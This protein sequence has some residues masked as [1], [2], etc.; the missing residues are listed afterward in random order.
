M[1]DDFDQARPITAN[2]QL[3]MDVTTTSI[4]TLL[5]AENLNGLE[6]YSTSSEHP[7]LPSTT[8]RRGENTRPEYG[9]TDE[10]QYAMTELSRVMRSTKN[11]RVLATGR[12]EMDIEE[13]MAAWCELQLGIKACLENAQSIHGDSFSQ[14]WPIK[15]DQIGYM[16]QILLAHFSVN[17]YLKSDTYGIQKFPA[18]PFL[19][20]KHNVGAWVDAEEA[21]EYC[22]GGKWGKIDFE[23]L[24]AAA[25]KWAN[26]Q[27][28]WK[29]LHVN[30]L[31]DENERGEILRFS[32]WECGSFPPP[33]HQPPVRTLRYGLEGEQIAVQLQSSGLAV[34][35]EREVLIT[36]ASAGSGVLVHMLFYNV[37]RYMFNI[38]YCVAHSES[39]V[40]GCGPMNTATVWRATATH[41]LTQKETDIHGFGDYMVKV[42]CHGDGSLLSHASMA[43]AIGGH[44]AMAQLLLGPGANPNDGYLVPGNSMQMRTE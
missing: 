13:S 6:S 37:K 21:A 28:I 43:T 25:E 35:G 16:K 15:Y 39:S 4:Q 34:C 33:Q 36:A 20:E 12:K 30:V 1:Q 5:T 24:L 23:D 7:A 11:S 18:S 9:K 31:K 10:R 29:G 17:E 8:M 44:E 2:T 40:G 14:P 41:I 27:E 26:G 3:P 22:M 19:E 32:L 42:H 38:S